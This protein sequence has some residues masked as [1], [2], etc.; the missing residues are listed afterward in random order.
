MIS[1]AFAAL[2]FIYCAAEV[3]FP[4]HVGTVYYSAR[5]RIAMNIVA[6]VPEYFV[7]QSWAVATLFLGFFVGPIVAVS[8]LR[9]KI[10]NRNGG[11]IS[12]AFLVAFFAIAPSLYSI[13][14][15]GALSYWGICCTALLL[16]SLAGS[17]LLIRK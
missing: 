9:Q 13:M 4:L 2:L 15:P 6:L 16:L 7:F 14:M 5:L 12:I 8:V 3:S 11:V 10:S 1:S 17:L